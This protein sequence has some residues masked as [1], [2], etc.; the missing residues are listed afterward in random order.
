MQEPHIH[1]LPVPP[2]AGHQATSALVTRNEEQPI[3]VSKLH[4]APAVSHAGQRGRPHRAE[5]DQ[6]TQGVK[7]HRAGSQYSCL[8]FKM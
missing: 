6:V 2:G 8:R 7:G 4:P 3:Q 1:A 5:E